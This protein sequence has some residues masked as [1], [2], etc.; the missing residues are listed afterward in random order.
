MNDDLFFMSV[1][2]LAL[3][4][5]GNLKDYACATWVDKDGKAYETI[6]F[7]KEEEQLTMVVDFFGNKKTNFKNSTIYLTCNPSSVFVKVARKKNVGR[8]IFIN[9]KNNLAIDPSDSNF[10]VPFVSS[11]GK[12]IDMFSQFSFI[13]KAKA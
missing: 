10:L 13:A 12:I 9:T 11:F 8:I 2:L 5:N 1:N 4:K 3:W 7:N 6:L